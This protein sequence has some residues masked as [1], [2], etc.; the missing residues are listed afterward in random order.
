MNVETVVPGSIRNWRARWQARWAGAHPT[1]RTSI[2][3][4]VVLGVV[5]FAYHY[6]LSSLLQGLTL[7]SPLAYVGLVPAIALGIAAT[8]S[9]P[10]AAEPAIHDRQVDYIVGLPLLAAAMAINLFMPRR[11]SSLF[12]IWRIDLLSLPLF[13]AGVVAIVFGVRVLWRQRLAIAYLLFAWPL[14]YTDLLLRLLNGFTNATLATLR[15]ILKVVPVAKVVPGSG[16]A[17]FQVTHNHRAF[18]LSVVSAC[19]GVNG[20]VGFLL[21]GAA[22]AGIVGGPRLRKTIWLLAGLALLWV[23]NLGRLVLIFWAGRTFGEPFAIDTLHPF[24]GLVTF[25]IG[26]LLMLLAMGPMGLHIGGTRLKAAART[27]VRKIEPVA[28]PRVFGAIVVVVVL[29]LIVG[30]ANS[31]LKAYNLVASATGEPKLA[32][33]SLDPATPKGWNVDYTGSIDW[34]TPYF[35]DSST[36]LRYVYTPAGS[37]N[38]AD[39]YS[40]DPI[41]ADVVNTNELD[42]FSAYGV[43][44]CYKFHGYKLRDVAQVTMGGGITGQVLSYNDGT[45]DW[46]ALYWIWPVTS[47]TGG[48][49]RYERVILYILNNAGASI[50]GP[51]SVAGVKGLQGA[52]SPASKGDQVLLSTRNF[53]VSF[54]REVIQ[55][56]SHV[57]PGSRLVS[58]PEYRQRLGQQNNLAKAP[59]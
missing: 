12:W 50:H 9:K 22:F 58:T 10:D 47:T 27:A 31:G 38:G 23:I 44:A 30:I 43:E 13:T 59:D 35:G 41:T 20:M 39:L 53:L 29:G 45:A 1:T 24:V 8:R 17:I 2:Q 57:T 49:T 54:G 25:N 4:A 28:V 40:S 37:A 18:P 48:P 42:S 52:L 5:A 11:L 19:S 6:S 16:G 7:E 36:W 33:Y 15:S 3:T 55:A 32:S 51:S 26:V 46:T 14:P 21:V 56:Q 34:A